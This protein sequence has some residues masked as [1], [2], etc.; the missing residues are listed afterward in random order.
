MKRISLVFL[1]AVAV[2]GVAVWWRFHSQGDRSDQIPTPTIPTAFESKSAGSPQ[3]A[4]KSRTATQAPSAP[5][6]Q[7]PT[8][9]PLEGQVV[10]A[11]G[12]VED[13][14]RQTA[15]MLL[16]EK[17][18]SDLKN[19]ETSVRTPEQ[20]RRLLELER[21][22]TT[23]L[24]ML[25][26]IAQFQNNPEEY[27]RFFGSLLKQAADLD[28]AQTKV[29]TDY[30][31]ERGTGLIA[32]GLNAANEPKDPAQEEPWEEKRDDYNEETAEGAIKLL[33]PGVAEKI[34]FSDKFLELLEQ[35]FD[36]AQ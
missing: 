28:A 33:P 14:G 24:G 22:R 4:E 16:G 23:T 2:V 5:A 30:F 17:E 20:R 8:E 6:A 13:I 9:T 19:M 11:L 10:V 29:L 36:K 1:A 31:R 27:S 3:T 26:E 15:A 7:I 21:Q 34:G 18:L 25:P 32:S 35:D 12:T